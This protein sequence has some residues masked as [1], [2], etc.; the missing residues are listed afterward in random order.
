[1]KQLGL[2]LNWV[3]IMCAGATV[4][5]EV[6][7]ASEPDRITDEVIASDI[8]VMDDLQDRLKRLNDQGVPI[9]SYH[10]AKA[11]AWLDF[12]R[13][14][15]AE[16]DRTGVIEAALNESGGIVRPLE[17]RATTISMETPII[18]SSKVVRE[19][20]WVRARALKGHSYF[21]CAE[22]KVAQMEVYLVWAGHEEGELGWRHAQSKIRTAER[23]EKDATRE[24][25]SCTP[26]PVIAVPMP[27]PSPAP[28]LSPIQQMEIL[29]NGVHFA[30]DKASIHPTTAVL[31]D[32][33]A[34]VLRLHPE[35]T[36]HLVG[37]TDRRGGDNYN[38]ALSD[39][40]AR[41]VRTYL[42]AAGVA[43]DRITK[44]AI[45]KR[46]APDSDQTAD[47]FARSRRVEFQFSQNSRIE[48]TPQDLD[49][50]PEAPS[51]N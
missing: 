14:E 38:L 13:A 31:L 8:Q 43:S 23:L 24:M 35:I 5:A 2:F 1:M 7:L 16:N 10:F 39:R 18:V 51:S 25:E 50:Q 27:P 19:D 42:L 40:R 17:M 20:L 12:A 48:Q 26:A 29:A 3:I 6:P 41:A 22:D 15:Y 45:G 47:E 4:W 44:E 11:Q 37:H 9:A 33:M 32:R 30:L 28:P 46:R 49:L 34:S 36:V 21:H